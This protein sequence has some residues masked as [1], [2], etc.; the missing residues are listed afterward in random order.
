MQVTTRRMF[1][2]LSTFALCGAGLVPAREDGAA[3]SSPGG[4]YYV[5]GTAANDGSIHIRGE[6]LPEGI[7]VEVEIAD[8]TGALTEAI[9]GRTG[10]DG[11]LEVEATELPPGADSLNDL[12]GREVKVVASDDGRVLLEGAFPR[13]RSMDDHGEGSTA[14]KPPAGAPFPEASGRARVKALDGRH[15]LEVKVRGLSERE[16]FAVRVTSTTGRSEVVGQ[17][18]TQGGGNG[19][20]KVDTDDGGTL[21]IASGGI[22]D[23]SGASIQVIDAGGQVVLEGTLPAIGQDE[24]NEVVVEVEIEFPES[25][26][27]H[28]GDR[29]D[30]SVT[31]KTS[32]GTAQVRLRLKDG[33]PGAAYD[34]TIR[35]ADSADRT[36]MARLTAGADGDAEVFIAGPD[37]LPLQAAQ[38]ADLAGDILEVVGPDGKV[39]LTATVPATPHAERPEP[40][41][42][43]RLTVV[44]ARPEG[45]A[46]SGAS[47]KV[48]L[49]E[50][51]DEHEIEIEAEGLVAGASYRA[52]IRGP[53]GAAE[54]LAEGSADAGGT[55]QKRLDFLFT[56]RLP[57][58]RAS[59]RALDGSTVAVLDATGAVVLEG[60]I[61]VPAAGGGG[62]VAS[63]I[64]FDMV[65]SFDAPFLRGDSNRDFALDISDVVF[66]LGYLFQGGSSPVCGDAMDSNDDG[67]PDISDAISTLFS[68]Y[69][70]GVPARFPGMLIAGF[71]PTADG[72]FCRGN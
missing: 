25:G 29:V 41:E 26:S 42:R 9:H 32:K 40:V 1:V 20:L 66:T 21:P 5:R 58:D 69:G 14:L 38:I 50:E 46:P 4:T 33:T 67:A 53:S 23:L 6:G 18:T 60:T 17:I 71:D 63:E 7:E 27:G 51:E 11:T 61:A 16:V 45:S 72:L 19:A 68:L 56:D 59:L 2:Y 49:E 65:G 43:L 22:A 70:G 31:F 15:A 64:S 37:A 34:F 39:L 8:D 13:E 12:A 28:G 54:T 36:V 30:G 57:F 52:E 47:G 48:E 24:A 44:L 55:F 35:P 62:A 10:D 3:L